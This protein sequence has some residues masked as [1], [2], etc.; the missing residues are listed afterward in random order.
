M[1]QKRTGCCPLP[2][3]DGLLLH[4]RQ[5]L[6]VLDS[7]LDFTHTGCLCPYWKNK[8]ENRD[9]PHQGHFFWGG[10]GGP[11]EG[12]GGGGGGGRVTRGPWER[13]IR[14]GGGARKKGGGAGKK[15]AKVVPASEDEV[16]D[17]KGLDN[18]PQ[19]AGV[20]GATVPTSGQHAWSMERC[21]W[22]SLERREESTRG[23]IRDAFYVVVDCCDM[24]V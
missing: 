6:Q 18:G 12:G 21:G 8:S 20:S 1:Y 4:C 10:G 24:V 13:E 22:C 2:S 17:A 16:S 11:G 7:T 14:K 15:A 19:G 3:R 5:S 23:G 9:Y